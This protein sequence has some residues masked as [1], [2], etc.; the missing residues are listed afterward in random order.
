MNTGKAIR[1]FLSHS[2]AD[3][4]FAERL[5][6]DL[7]GLGE[8]WFY[9]NY[10]IAAGGLIAGSISKA[11]DEVEFFVC[12]LSRT[13]VESQWVTQEWSAAMTRALSCERAPVIIPLLYQ[14][15]E[16][17]ALLA[18]AK[19]IDFRD[20]ARYHEA[21]RELADRLGLNY[22]GDDNRFRD[23]SLFR[24]PNEQRR[25]LFE[26]ILN[27]RKTLKTNELNLR[28][29]SVLD[30][31]RRKDYDFEVPGRTFIDAR[32]LAH[33]VA[34]LVSEH[35]RFDRARESSPLVI[36]ICGFPGLGKTTFSRELCLTFGREYRKTCS[37][38]E[39]E[40]WMKS[41]SERW[42]GDTNLVSGFDPSAFHY[43]ELAA[44]VKQLVR[45][46]AVR[47]PLRLDGERTSATS[48]IQPAVVLILD[49]VLSFLDEFNC[50]SDFNV[51]FEA[52]L[53][54]RYLLSSL[55]DSYVRQYEQQKY[56]H[57][58]QIHEQT[59]PC[60]IQLLRNRAT[61]IAMTSPFHNYRCYSLHSEER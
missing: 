26:R 39:F 53:A 54:T 19:Y 22:V 13:S 45:G 18:S 21:L 46:Q 2:S 49:G 6:G 4:A 56:E 3:N 41:R 10:S 52:D 23:E 32:V 29:S 20:G 25:K 36:S 47:Q 42:D 15:T 37:I 57:K 16:V 5:V 44:S 33:Y 28:Q 14:D 1:I 59:Y 30:L 48:P 9:D 24:M 50:L 60:F 40:K 51:Y 11:L 58:F 38:V 55:K 61:L 17:P 12:V 43:D 7:S 8:E 35:P 34:D 31:Y 27:E